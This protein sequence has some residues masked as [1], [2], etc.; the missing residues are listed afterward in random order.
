MPLPEYVMPVL[1]TGG[2]VAIVFIV[3]RLGP[4]AVLRLLAGFVVVLT[5]NK[6]RGDR[7][8]AVLRILR[9]REDDPSGSSKPAELSP[10]DS[11]TSF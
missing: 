5:S 6:E 1:A 2:P 3:L 7:C 8:L 4:D 9:N 10:D 11:R